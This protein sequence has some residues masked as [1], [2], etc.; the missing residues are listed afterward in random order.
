M[1]SATTPP[2]DTNAAPDYR[3]LLSELW[4]VMNAHGS[5]TLSVGRPL[6]AGA[7]AEYDFVLEEALLS[8]DLS[9]DGFVASL[10][11]M[12]AHA[13]RGPSYDDPES[14]AVEQQRVDAHVQRVLYGTPAPTRP[15]LI[16]VPGGES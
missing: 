1:Q 14:I 13:W 3:S 8:R 4:N 7:S 10:A 16:L 9:F 15:H 12:L 6:T 11:R 2:G 5:I